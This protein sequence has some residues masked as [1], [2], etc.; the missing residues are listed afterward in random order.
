MI[1]QKCI[2]KTIK[3]YKNIKTRIPTEANLSNALG[4]PLAEGKAKIEEPLQFTE[5]LLKEYDFDIFK[6][7]KRTRFPLVEDPQKPYGL[8]DLRNRGFVR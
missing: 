2:I 6:N 1:Q 8:K 7:I 5:A 3:Y 4:I